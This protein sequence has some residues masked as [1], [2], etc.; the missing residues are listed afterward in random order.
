M[1]VYLNSIEMGDG[2]YGVEAVAQEHFGKHAKRLTKREAA[3]I[4][5]SLPN[6]LKRDSGNPTPAMNRRSRAIMDLM[7]KIESFD[8]YRQAKNKGDEDNTAK[9][10][11]KN[12][13]KP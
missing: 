10:K 6:P 12:K 9:T 13:R 4:A 11:K 8:A 2:I 3:L 5:V 1:E 7:G